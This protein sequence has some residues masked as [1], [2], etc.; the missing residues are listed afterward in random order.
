MGV[1]REA[2]SRPT[3][4]SLPIDVT[5]LPGRLQQRY[6][7]PKDEA[8]RQIDAWPKTAMAQQLGSN[9]ARNRQKF[10]RI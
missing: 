4:P 9:N 6:G 3:L 10:H 7:L 1:S 5:E 8:E 2:M